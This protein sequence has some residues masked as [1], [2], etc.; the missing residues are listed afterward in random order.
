MLDKIRKS[1]H[2]R[3]WGLR[4]LNDPIQ[5]IG[6]EKSAIETAKRPLRHELINFLLAASGS[7]DKRYLEIGVRNPAD[8]FNKIEAS[9]KHSVDPGIEFEANPVEF[10]LTSDAFFNQLEQGI[11]LNPSIRFDVIFIDGLHLAEQVARD[12]K[13]A[14]KF[15]KE[16]GFIVLHDCNPPTEFHAREDYA[17]TL[18]PA[19]QFWNGT[20]WKAFY[21]CRLD[22]NLSCCVIDSD[23]GLGIISKRTF[24]EALKEDLNPYL[25]FQVF[26]KNRKTSLNLIEF[27]AFKM[28]LQSAAKS[29]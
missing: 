26:E 3:D 4:Y 12:I 7:D 13:N 20:T 14:L 21:R 1:K 9:Q 19:R 6:A 17:Y 2:Q 16:D 25:E 23:W 29:K 10:K 27:D 28:H 5:L 11:I 24:Y 22:K 18:S 8:N 15:I